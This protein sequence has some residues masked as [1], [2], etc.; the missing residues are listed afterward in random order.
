MSRP[1]QDFSPGSLPAV[2]VDAGDVGE[3]GS[4]MDEAARRA[5]GRPVAQVELGL[6]D[7]VARAGG[8]PAQRLS[9]KTLVTNSYC[10]LSRSRRARNSLRTLVST[11]T[12]LTIP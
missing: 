1:V 12:A 3:L 7:A 8:F 9:V 11:S 5:S 6:H 4:A 10:V 2:E